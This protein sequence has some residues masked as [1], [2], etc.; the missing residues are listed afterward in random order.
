MIKYNAIDSYIICRFVF[1]YQF[2]GGDD[3]DYAD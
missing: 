3:G 2:Y 1:K